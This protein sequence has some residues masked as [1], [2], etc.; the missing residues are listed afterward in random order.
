MTYHLAQINI[1]RLIAPL[2]DPKIAEFVSQLDPINALADKAPGFV[3]RLQSQSGNATDIAY[4]DDPFVIVN[5]SV[6]TSMEALRDFAYKS[7]HA[8]VFRDR[9]KWFEKMDRPQL[10][11]L[12]DPSGPHSHCRRGPRASRALSAARRHA[13]SLLVFTALSAAC[14]RGCL[15]LAQAPSP[16][17]KKE[18]LA[19]LTASR[20]QSDAVS[21][22][23]PRHGRRGRHHE[24]RRRGLHREIRR[25]HGIH[26][27]GIRHRGRG[28]RRHAQILRDRI[29]CLEN[30]HGPSRARRSPGLRKTH[31]HSSH[32]RKNRGRKSPDVHK[33]RETMG[34]RR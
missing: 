2:D 8:R 6:W 12:V 29:L 25:H 23:V 31:G 5:M 32:D 1:A 7:D 16:I 9:A 22:I 18:R 15:R 27:L 34:L 26:H 17:P 33:I 13:V 11:P 14:E 10:L 3:W 21:V 28:T 4:N 19:V 20:P 30:R 24:T